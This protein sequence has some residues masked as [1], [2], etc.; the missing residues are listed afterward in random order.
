MIKVIIKKLNVEQQQYYNFLA[1]RCF[2]AYSDAEAKF[3]IHRYVSSATDIFRTLEYFWKSLIILDGKYFETTHEVDYSSFLKISKDLL[4]NQEKSNF[5]NILSKFSETRRLLSIYG[6]YD[7]PGKITMP[8]FEAF[9]K[10][11]V[12][13]DLKLAGQLVKKLKEIHY[14]QLFNPP[15]KIGVLSGYVE[16]IDNE[17]P[18]SHYRWSNFKKA[19]EWRYDLE[20][21]TTKEGSKLFMP[22]LINIIE[23]NTGSFPIVINPF[24]ET[25]PEKERGEGISTISRYINDGGVFV[26]SGGYPFVE[27]WDVS[28]G[29]YNEVIRFISGFSGVDIIG[30]N[31]LISESKVMLIEASYLKTIFDVEL[32]L[33]NNPLG[34]IGPQEVEMEYEKLLGSSIIKAQVFRAP[35]RLTPN[36][37]PLARSKTTPWGEICPIVA[38][39]YGRGFLIH[40][41]MNLDRENEYKI[42]LDVICQIALK[43]YETL[44]IS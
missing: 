17:I 39:K 30:N 23:L 1:H 8:P 24:G 13:N 18:C 15:I 3:K 31:V 44:A 6:S 34:I 12:E 42:L 2:E 37:I 14:Y 40:T 32:I 33:D 5:Q 26:N 41:G 9:P 19:N 28:T 29:K 43:G 22:D 38:I 11:E 25:F 27:K 21:I 4:S 10:T 36:I 16:D 20:Q 7:K 35:Q